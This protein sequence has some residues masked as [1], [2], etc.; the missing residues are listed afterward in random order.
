[1]TDYSLNNILLSFADK[2]GNRR[3]LYNLGSLGGV[4]TNIVK[5]FLL[6]LPFIEYAIIFNPVVFNFLGIATAIVFFI[7]F[8]SIVM[9]IVFFVAWGIKKSVIKKITPSWNKYFE[10]KDLHMVLSAGVTPYSDF[11][12]HLSQSYQENLSEDEMHKSLLKAFLAM[13]EENADLISAMYRNNKLT[14]KN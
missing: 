3:T 7:V 8:L 2:N 10:G 14:S 12:T 5:I 9:L 1:M 6:S 4:N 13:E 11:Y